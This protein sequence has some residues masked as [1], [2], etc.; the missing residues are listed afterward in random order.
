M[1]PALARL[2]HVTGGCPPA[3]AR[4]VLVAGICPPPSRDWFALGD[5]GA[6]ATPAPLSTNM[7]CS[8]HSV[9]LC[10]TRGCSVF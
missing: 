2:V 5:G 8:G 6:R 3:L 9:T 10:F 4:L 7:L 1:P